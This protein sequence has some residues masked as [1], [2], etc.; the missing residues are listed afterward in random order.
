MDNQIG[1]GIVDPVAALTYDVPTGEAVA[2]A[3]LSTPL[4]L[5]PP[6]VGRDMTPVWVA[7]GG[8][9]SVALLSAVVVGL[10]AMAR[11]RSD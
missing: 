11:S 9:G 7:V 4:I 1:H 10:A 8:V 3:R 6:P 2:P 5:P